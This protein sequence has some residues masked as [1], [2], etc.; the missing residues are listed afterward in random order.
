MD[1]IMTR[2]ECDYSRSEC[3][4]LNIKPIMDKIDKMNEK[5]DKLSIEIAKLPEGIF[6]EAEKRFASK[7][8][9]KF[10]WAIGVIATSA[11]IAAVFKLI[12]K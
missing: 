6:K 3:Y 10:V 2:K 1:D 11:I 12:F 4:K 9:E 7:Q 8:L 5:L